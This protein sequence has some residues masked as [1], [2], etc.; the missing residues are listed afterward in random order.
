MIRQIGAIF[1][2]ILMAFA[3][4]SQA[5]DVESAPQS[6]AR[7]DV[8]QF[9]EASRS[10]FEPTA[11]YLPQADA[12]FLSQ[13]IDGQDMQWMGGYWYGPRGG[14]L[15]LLNCAGQ[16]IA[17]SKLGFIEGL[18]IGPNVDGRPSL[19]VRYISG[20][21]TGIY[22]SSTALVQYR[23]GSLKVLWSHVVRSEINE[24]P[25]D[26]PGYGEDMTCDDKWKLSS[27]GKRIAVTQQCKV[28]VTDED[29]GWAPGSTHTLP[30]E[31]YCWDKKLSK[32][33]RCHTGH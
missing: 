22:K 13:R 4:A 10:R 9:L 31:T 32:F 23:E 20:D 26:K 28:G 5:S 11:D 2:S 12:I 1:A 33:E 24:P 14:V 16:E 17:Y 29:H 7:P 6:C 18:N 3:G 30:T 15:L 21:G 19:T 25:L 27:T 8:V